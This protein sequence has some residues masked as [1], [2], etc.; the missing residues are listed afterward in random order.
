[1]TIS[2]ASM[3]ASYVGNG[4]TTVFAVPFEF[5]A[6][7]DLY[8]KLFPDVAGFPDDFVNLV[9]GVDFTVTG[10]N[11]TFG[12]VTLAVAPPSTAQ[13]DILGN[14]PLGQVVQYQA[15][16]PFPAEAHERALDRLSVQIKQIATNI[17]FSPGTPPGS[18]TVFSVF[19]RDG[20]VVAQIVDYAAFYSQLD[21]AHT[22]SEIQNKPT[23]FPPAAHVH[24]WTEIQSKP[25]VFPPASHTHVWGEITDAAEQAQDLVASMLVHAGHVNMS[26][27]YDDATGLIVG[28][29]TGG[30]SSTSTAERLYNYSNNVSMTDPGVGN[31]R[32]NNVVFLSVTEIVFS[33]VDLDGRSPNLEGVQVGD[34]ITLANQSQLGYGSYTVGAVDHSGA[35]FS[36]FTVTVN[37]GSTITGN[38]PTNN[39]DFVITFYHTASGVSEAPTDGQTYGRK[40][41]GWVLIAWAA[42]SGKPSTFPPAAHN[43]PISEVTGL[44]SALA[45]K[46]DV[47][48]THAITDVTG[49][50]VALSNKQ[51]IDGT[52]TALAALVTGVGS[53]IYSTAADTFATIAT[54]AFGR[55]ILNWADAVAGRTALDV[56]QKGIVPENPQTGTSYTLVLA[57]R[58]KLVAMNNAGA[59]ALTL[60]TDAVANFP[61]NTRIDLWQEGAGQVTVG[62]AG[63]TILSSGGKKKLTGQYSGATLWKKAA[64]TWA[65]IGDIAA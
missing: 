52:L 17:A 47:G 22:W 54:T 58:G 57:D 7:T 16:G 49:L 11:G 44:S 30:G 31:F 51:P 61:L 10:G 12:Q 56:D 37:P 39:N 2:N 40:D 19:G 9:Y 60:P 13:L 1:M 36:L 42:I 53:M 35:G 45:G 32:M 14:V 63:V 64:D 5:F 6:L 29:A 41:T 33:N 65:L 3:T 62:G 8:L 28:T 27:T 4:V 23:L 25:V 24:N 21:H 50:D 20:N 55:G 34:V 59:I 48:H 46:T 26:F 38:N 43:H 18:G 15:H